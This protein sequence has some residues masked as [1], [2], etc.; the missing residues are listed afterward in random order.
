MS[1]IAVGA[2]LVLAMVCGTAGAWAQPAE[3]R[4]AS[5]TRAGEADDLALARGL[6]RAFQRVARTIE[7][8]VVHIVSKQS[9]PVLER[10]GWFE[11]RDTGRRQVIE[12]GMGSGV[13]VSKD[14][15]ILTNNH[16]VADAEMLDVRLRDGRVLPGKIVGRDPLTDIA[17]V[18]VESSELSAVEFGD[19]DT[20]EVGEWVVA[21][22]SPF[23]FENSVTAG[24]VSAKSRSRVP[25]RELGEDAY[26]DFI[27]TDASINPGNSGGPLL[28]LDGRLI[29]INSAIATRA[30]GSEGIGFAIPA[31][32]A[33]AVMDSIVR[34]GRVVRGWLGVS[35]SDLAGGEARSL[36]LE[37]NSGVLVR[38]VEEDSPAKRAG[39]RPGDVVVRYQNRPMT[40]LS[41]LRA[42]V[43]LTQPGTKV[44]MQI[45]REGKPQTISATIGDFEAA[46]GIAEIAP[47]GILVRTMPREE[48]RRVRNFD[49]RGV[50]V[51]QVVPD[52]PAARSGLQ[53]G[54]IIV[55][56]DGKAVS[57]S[58]GLRD[59][60]GRSN[61]AR[62]VALG[63]IR[64]NERGTI[65]LRE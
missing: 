26:K 28:D 37:P 31:N 11:V 47:W 46:Q 20:V 1:R 16:V 60:A 15:L 29:G 23:G 30:G 35:F 38:S 33:K 18:R 22:G 8:S 36:G 65:T 17:V 21:I 52:S 48:S 13:I 14:G 50:V 57:T 58:E 5:E 3:V 2:A 27:Q 49:V 55:L 51:T 53:T 9:R 54:D 24:I 61:L 44:E 25:L 41:T 12:N 34:N 10:V 32:M 63:V 39:L 62:G 4:P 45:M 56:V 59:L 7:P 6:S 64:G 42:A 43:A 40:Q 19:S